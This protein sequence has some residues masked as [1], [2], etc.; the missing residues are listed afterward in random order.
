MGR[1]IQPV[2]A[3]HE[4]AAGERFLLSNGAALALNEIGAIL[5]ANLAAHGSRVPTRTIPNIVL[6]VLA[7]FKPEFRAFVPD[8]VYLKKTSNEEAQRILGWAPRAPGEAIVA[9]AK[10]MV[11]RRLSGS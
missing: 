11:D 5:K 4:R 2:D 9:A 3:T 8:L 6:R 10:S 7:L 1:R